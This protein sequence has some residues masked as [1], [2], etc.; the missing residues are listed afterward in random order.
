MQ[1]GTKKLIQNVTPI[2]GAKRL[3]VLEKDEL[4]S[5]NETIEFSLLESVDLYI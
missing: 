2:G 5:L 4:I 1:S 3:F